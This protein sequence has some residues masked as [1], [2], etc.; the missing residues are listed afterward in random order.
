MGE[1]GF[2]VTNLEAVISFLDSVDGRSL[3][4]G[5]LE[6]KSNRAITPAF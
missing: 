4:E 6:V 5:I 2:L 1:S 3:N